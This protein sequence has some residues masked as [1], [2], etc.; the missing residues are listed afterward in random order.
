MHQFF[1]VGW[2][3]EINRRVAYPLG[4]VLGMELNDHP[5]DD[6]TLVHGWHCVPLADAERLMP[7]LDVR[8][9]RMSAFDE[10]IRK[11]RGY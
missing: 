8:L 6:G 4:V 11:V 10:H 1:E 5:G 2:L 7:P 3:H 9:Q